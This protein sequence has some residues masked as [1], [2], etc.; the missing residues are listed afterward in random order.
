MVTT[1][2]RLFW[3]PRAGVGTNLF[4]FPRAGVGTNLGRASVPYCEPRRWRVDTAFPRRRVGTRNLT[5]EPNMRTLTLILLVTC[6]NT[7]FAAPEVEEYNFERYWPVLKQPWYF[8]EVDDLAMDSK[9]NIYVIGSQVQKYT[10]DGLLIKSLHSSR[11]DFYPFAITIDH[12]DNVYVLSRYWHDGIHYGFVVKFNANGNEDQDWKF[13]QFDDILPSGIAVDSN[14]HVYVTTRWGRSVLKLAPDGGAAPDWQQKELQEIVAIDDKYRQELGKDKLGKYNYNQKDLRMAIDSHN[15]FYILVDLDVEDY[16]T[17]EGSDRVCKSES[18]SESACQ[19]SSRV[20][21]YDSDF[22]FVGCWGD[23]HRPH[24]IT[25]DKQDHIYITDSLGFRVLKYTSTSD[26]D[27]EIFEVGTTIDP[28]TWKK[29]FGLSPLI[30]NLNEELLLTDLLKELIDKAK[31][32][33]D[34]ETGDNDEKTD[35]LEELLRTVTGLK[36]LLYDNS[37]KNK[38]NVSVRP[39]AIAVGGPENNTA[40]F[41]TYDYP[42][43]SIRKFASDGDTLL[44]H[45]SSSGNPE[46]GKFYTPTKLAL[47]KDGYLYVT[48]S[49]N[50]RIVKFDSEGKYMIAW[51]K[52]GDGKSEFILPVGIT[53]DTIN[54][55]VFVYVVDVGNVRIQ[56]F[57]AD[58]GFVAEWPLE[59]G[60]VNE[61]SFALPLAIAV[62]SHHNVYVVDSVKGDIKKFDSDGNYQMIFGEG[63]GDGDSQFK[64]AAGIAIDKD[65]NIYVTDLDNHRVQQFDV[66][67]NFVWKFGREGDHRGI[68]QFDAPLDVTT[69]DASNVYVADASNRRIQK[70]KSACIQNQNI[71]ETDCIITYGSRG[72]SP[73]KFGGSGEFAV[74]G[75][76]AVTPD[77]QRVYAVDLGNNR[78]QVFSNEKFSPGKAI[79]IAGRSGERD[80]LWDA[81]Q[82]VANSAYYVLM[83]Q[84]FL[85]SDIRYLSADINLELDHDGDKDVDGK[86]TLA[87]VEE[88]I[89]WAGENGNQNLT[90]YMVDHGG[91]GED[92]NGVFHLNVNE[93][94]KSTDLN[95]WLNKYIQAGGSV[96]IIYDAC[97]SGSFL[98]HLKSDAGDNWTVIVSATAEQDA[99]FDSQGSLSFSNFFW[100]NIFN[101]LTIAEA[102]EQTSKT[103][104]KR[105]AVDKKQ[106]PQIRPVGYKG[107]ER[108]GNGTTPDYYWDY[109]P[110]LI[111][112]NASSPS[113]EN[114]EFDYDNNSIRIAADV[115]DPDGINEVRA[116]VNSPTTLRRGARGQSIVDLPKFYLKPTAEDRYEAIYNGF[117]R[118]GTYNITIHAKDALG[119]EAQPQVVTVNVVNVRE[120]KAI[121]IV[122]AESNK[123]NIKSAY[124]ALQHKGIDGDNILL[125][126]DEVIAGVDI[127]P[128]PIETF[129]AETDTYLNTRFQDDDIR[130]LV[131]YI[132]GVNDTVSLYLDKNKNFLLSF[133]DIATNLDNLKKRTQIEHITVVYEDARSGH[134]LPALA[135]PE[136]CSGDNKE[137]EK[138]KS[139]TVI[140]STDM[141][142][143]TSCQQNVVSFSKFFWQEIS[144]G[145]TVQAAF[146]VA[147]NAVVHAGYISQFDINAD[148]FYNSLG[149]ESQEGNRDEYLIGENI[150]RATIA[151]NINE[152]SQPT[153]LDH[154]TTMADLWA[155]VTTT[156]KLKRVWAVICSPDDIETELDL[157]LD[158]NSKYKATKTFIKQGNYSVHFYAED[159]N[160]RIS[161]PSK[162]TRTK[163]IQTRSSY[164][165]P[166]QS[167]YH[168]GDMVKVT[169]PDL[170]LKDYKQYI[171]IELPDGQIFVVTEPGKFQLYDGKEPPVWNGKGNTVIDGFAVTSDTLRGEYHLHL[172]LLHEEAE[173]KQ[174]PDMNTWAEFIFKVEN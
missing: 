18:N 129:V 168:N 9:H 1:R 16:I 128:I 78:V 27:R 39:S 12:E 47:D 60:I 115:I 92:G 135:L 167:V 63:F 24:G 108:I 62:D 2:R 5:G 28:E 50:N 93:T 111:R 6:L 70:I 68:G 122:G 81:T 89:K 65:D 96:K 103:I 71:D 145:S 107:D 14:K 157:E 56:K 73:G 166:N 133:E 48:D 163:V 126:S 137:N 142:S 55:E 153:Y 143:I 120:H 66:D 53:T 97:R 118:R 149:G 150:V 79:I 83:Y 156:E 44:A 7:V 132:E 134:L 64:I 3:F 20:C 148:G 173:F 123:Q 41:V 31:N 94:L 38:K 131:I 160:G 91:N 101:G 51:G 151:P 114:S 61:N 37:I 154:E 130:S 147:K 138:C 11:K 10:F 139:R 88:A 170:R 76:I 105:F 45:W 23:F 43:Q 146:N 162:R 161:F 58:G 8:N 30:S 112:K 69:D 46:E 54:G 25:V 110:E 174:P 117:S 95:K 52:L 141:S 57:R 40:I 113:I 77:E 72:T 124:E 100:G 33:S 86:P 99:Y 116:T 49:L 29:T 15:N 22:E 169:L 127:T 32:S 155:D 152:V 36:I 19:G 85:K 158:N 104:E 172:I 34:E 159:E 144:N 35:S 125:V 164:L 42:H 140:T 102:F 13:P 109:I 171:G 119:N 17:E 84:R 82:A 98:P 165:T 121:I 80:N 106:T 4:W 21:K 59:L 90:L 26:E 87:N 74:V 67:G 136:E 75:G